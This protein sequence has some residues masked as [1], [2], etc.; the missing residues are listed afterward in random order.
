MNENMRKTPVYYTEK[1]WRNHDID[2]IGF[3]SSSEA[4]NGLNDLV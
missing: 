3:P 2:K 4:I 1:S